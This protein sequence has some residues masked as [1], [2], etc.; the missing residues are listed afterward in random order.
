[1]RN[2]IIGFILGGSIGAGITYVLMNRKMESEIELAREEYKRYYERKEI[3]EMDAMAS[4][5]KAIPDKPV[6]EN[7]KKYIDLTKEYSSDVDPAEEEGPSE[8]DPLENE[9]IVDD[10]IQEHLEK[11]NDKPKIIPVESFGE[12]AAYEC[13]CLKFY[14]EDRTLVHEDGNLVDDIEFLIG[15]A[16]DRYDWANNDEEESDLYVRNYKLQR[17]YEI[18]KIFGEYPID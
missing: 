8:D 18:T 9:V 13:E 5:E 17:D 6:D 10:M 4:H 3:E 16:L 11:T 7:N 1:M 2:L 15:D 14:V 12:L